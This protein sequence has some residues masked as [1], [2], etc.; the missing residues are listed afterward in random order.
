MDVK[1]P[2]E[3]AHQFRGVQQ[4]FKNDM[5]TSVQMLSVEN[6]QAFALFMELEENLAEDYV[7]FQFASIYTSIYQTQVERVVTV[8]LPTTS[9]LTNYLRSVQDEVRAKLFLV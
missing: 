2:G 4:P 9:S 5:A 3:E 7:Y 8:Q 1:G 6:T